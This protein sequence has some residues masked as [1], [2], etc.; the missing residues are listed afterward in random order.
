M[1]LAETIAPQLPCL[2]VCSRPYGSQESGDAMW[3]P[4]LETLVADPR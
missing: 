4:V 2:E 1:S 3:W